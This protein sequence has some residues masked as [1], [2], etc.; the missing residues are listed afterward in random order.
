MPHHPNRPELAAAAAL[1]LVALSLV[2][3]GLAMT[4]VGV[5][6][7]Q[8]QPYGNE[9]ANASDDGWTEG[10][11][12]VTLANVT[13]YVSRVGTF[14]VGED[15]SDAGVGPIFTGLVVGV[16][17]VVLLGTS[18]SGLIASGTMSVLV[19]AGLAAP[20]GAGL[21]PR[22]LYGVV[23][24]LVALVAGVLYVRTVR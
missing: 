7:A 10:H 1:A 4:G 16:F 12:D 21:L 22:W 9:T 18:R 24:M 2:T 8:E 11:R 23:V 3:G 15:P 19:A 5:A 20:S 14:F 13:H 17:S 6:D